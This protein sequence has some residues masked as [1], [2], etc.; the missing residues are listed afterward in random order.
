MSKNEKLLIPG[1]IL[2]N[3]QVLAKIG[4]YKIKFKASHRSLIMNNVAVARD[5]S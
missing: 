4:A 5:G 1:F 3:S 2:Y